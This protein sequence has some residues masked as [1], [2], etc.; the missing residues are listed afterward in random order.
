MRLQ[1]IVPGYLALAAEVSDEACAELRGW[2]PQPAELLRI[3]ALESCSTGQL[4]HNPALI[5]A[6]LYGEKLGE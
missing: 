5:G 6:Q 3:S 2:L 4:T 1:V